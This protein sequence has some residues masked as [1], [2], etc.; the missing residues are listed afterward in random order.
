[1]HTRSSFD[2][3]SANYTEVINSVLSFT[4]AD[5]ATYAKLRV[6][7]LKKTVKLHTDKP[8]L[9]VLDFGC[10]DGTTTLLIRSLFN[11]DVIGVDS[12]HKSL[13]VAQK[14]FGSDRITFAHEDDVQKFKPF[15]LVYCNGVFH[16][17]SPDKRAPTIEII[18]DS[19]APNGLFGFFE[20]TP[21]NPGTRLVM[22]EIPFDKNAIVISPIQI[23]RMLAKC[24]F[25][26]LATRY[27]F[28]I[29][30]FLGPL[31]FLDGYLRWLPIGGQ[32]LVL[33]KNRDDYFAI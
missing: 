30:P 26:V 5:R 15:D 32:Y 18:K 1:M 25:K 12:S 4:G 8:I 21:W 28:S 13:E 23:K 33:G 29:P 31:F 22:R 2:V 10:G 14:N 24:G 7:E 17:I 27:L 19:L 6:E 11:A 16:H 9:R 3:F 20:N